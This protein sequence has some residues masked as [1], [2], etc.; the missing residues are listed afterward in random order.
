MAGLAGLALKKGF[1]VTGQDKSY[2]PPMSDQLRSLEIQENKTEKPISDLKK[3]DAIIIGNSQSRGNESVEY[4]LDNQLNYF[5]GPE[6]IKENILKD[7]YVFVVSG[8][9]GKTTTT[10][11]L[12]KILQDNNKNPSFLVGGIYK[13]ENISYKYTNSDYF[14]IEGDEYDTSF[15]DKRSKFFHYK[16]N[17]LIINNLEYDHSDIFD[18]LEQI[19]KQFHFLIRT[20]PSNSNIIY[21]GNDQNILDLLEMGCWAKKIHYKK[22]NDIPNIFGDHNLKNAS[23]A[24]AAANLISIQEKN[25]L[26]ALEKFSGVKRRLELIENKKFIVYD[27]FA[28]HPT[29]ISS[30]IQAVKSIHPGKNIAVIFEIRSNSMISGSH[31]KAF[32]KSF[33]NVKELYIYCEKEITWLDENSNIAV[34]KDIEQ[35]TQQINNNIDNV[36]IVIVMSNGDTTEILK[37]LE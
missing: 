13:E 1:K 7:K 4:I 33:L 32:L 15:F 26:K 17:T 2:F 29:A 20:M 18:N 9:H 21:D 14:V 11:M 16:P 37:Q 22:I 35:I 34:Y 3:S 6:W 10:S 36:D 19:K 24:L 27:D 8:T 28:H 31:K 23:A 5:S 30:S 12:I 25:S